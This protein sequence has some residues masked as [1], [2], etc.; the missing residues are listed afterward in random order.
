MLVLH[1][2]KYDVVS[3]NLTRSIGENVGAISQC[4]GVVTVISV[5]LLQQYCFH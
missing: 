2:V 1:T 5:L 4:C 3:R